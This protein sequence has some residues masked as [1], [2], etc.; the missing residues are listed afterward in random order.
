VTLTLSWKADECKPL[1]HGPFESP[2]IL[3]RKLLIEPVSRNYTDSAGMFLRENYIQ[4]KRWSMVR[5]GVWL[6]FA[7]HSDSFALLTHSHPSYGGPVS[8]CL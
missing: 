3:T 8:D 6:L 2:L 4:H 1:T 7:V 5:P